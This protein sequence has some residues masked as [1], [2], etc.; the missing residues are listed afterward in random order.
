MRYFLLYPEMAA[1]LEAMYKKFRQEL[2]FLSDSE[3][4][5][6]LQAKRGIELSLQVLRELRG[7]LDQHPPNSQEEEISFFKYVKPK[8]ACQLRFYQRLYNLQLHL[9][10]GGPSTLGLYYTRILHGIGD[11]L[12]QNEEIDIYMRLGEGEY[13][14]YFFLRTSE[15]NIRSLEFL[16]SDGDPLFST[17]LD[18]VVAEL[19]ADDLMFLYLIHQLEKI[20]VSQGTGSSTI[21]ATSK[22]KWTGP[23]KGLGQL[24]RAM[25]RSRS[26]NHGN[27]TI[28]EVAKQFEG[29]FNV[30]LKNIYRAAQEDRITKEPGA[31]LK[32]LYEVLLQDYDDMDQNP[33]RT[34]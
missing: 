29:L 17:A 3:I 27:I 8:F 14:K 5:P 7:W 15:V 33:K 18:H 16:R 6:L 4:D 32:F 19:M 2:E 11:H 12:R 22:L 13:D 26:I 30:D 34:G 28:S 23:V 24:I 10:A 1:D 31:Y 25:V 20:S 21:P 9:P